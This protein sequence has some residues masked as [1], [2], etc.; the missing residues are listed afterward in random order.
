MPEG[1]LALARCQERERRAYTCL[2][3][4]V[5][6]SHL[7][8]PGGRREHAGRGVQTLLAEM[9]GYRGRCGCR[10]RRRPCWQ[11]QIDIAQCYGDRPVSLGHGAAAGVIILRFHKASS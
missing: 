10:S 1:L 7:T 5:A 4:S 3:A 2:V 11:G 9:T 8:T 6:D